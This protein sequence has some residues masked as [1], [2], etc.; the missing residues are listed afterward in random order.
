MSIQIL[1][2]FMGI[3]NSRVKIFTE[4]EMRWKNLNNSK[5]SGA[6]NKLLKKPLVAK[7]LDRLNEQT[8][9]YRLLQDK[10]KDGVTRQEMRQILGKL[11]RD[12]GRT[13][14]RREAMEIA[15]AIFPGRFTKRYDFS[16]TRGHGDV[17]R[18]SDI[19]DRSAPIAESSSVVSSRH[20]SIGRQRLSSGT[21]HS[22]AAAPM[23]GYR[24]RPGQRSPVLQVPISPPRMSKL[25]P[26]SFPTHF[27]NFNVKVAGLIVLLILV[28]MSGFWWFGMRDTGDQSKLNSVVGPTMSGS[29]VSDDSS[30]SAGARYV[31]Y[32]QGIVNGEGV[33]NRR[34][35]FF[36]ASWCPF[37]R[38]A[39]VEFR[40]RMNEIPNDV[41]VIRVNYNDS[42]TDEGEKS[43]ARQYGVTYQHTFVQIDPDGTAVTTWNGGKLKELLNHIK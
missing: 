32:P 9:L 7:M 14:D 21:T 13:I 19:S 24:R 1:V 38:P 36:Y 40:E 28:I 15:H 4:K 18:T 10:A 34:V 20:P 5:K 37:C 26:N 30:Q 35:L 31:E 43:L 17:A 33:S 12:G 23:A 6:M 41:T 22:L 29:L 8:E 3:F 39:D 2:L 42:D 11:R 25:L 16:E 27:G